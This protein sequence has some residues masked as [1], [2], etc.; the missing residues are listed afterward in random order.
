MLL[1]WKWNRGRCW[2]CSRTKFKIIS[3]SLGVLGFYQCIAK[4]SFRQDF[5]GA[6]NQV[7]ISYWITFQDNM[8][9]D[10]SLATGNTFNVLTPKDCFAPHMVVGF[11]SIVYFVSWLICRSYFVKHQYI[12]HFCLSHCGEANVTRSSNQ[13]SDKWWW[14]LKF[15]R[16]YN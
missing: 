3:Q 9:N 14:N 13:Y 8:W 11:A 6:V 16:K 10:N 1:K 4:A 7:D 2:S 5:M 12:S 15:R